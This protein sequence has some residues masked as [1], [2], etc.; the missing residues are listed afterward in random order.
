[1]PQKLL[2]SSQVNPSHHKTAGESVPEAMPGESPNLGTA[3]C[4]LKPV[5]R[6]NQAFAPW[7]TNDRPG[8]VA[9]LPKFAKACERST[10][11]WH[12]AS[13]DVVVMTHRGTIKGTENGKEVTES[14]RSLHVFQ[15]LNGQWRVVANAQLPIAK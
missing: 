11:Q 2:D 7:I 3:E 4:W 10:I 5:S 15:K 12:I 8:S 13:A 14:H 6:A 9:A 1:M